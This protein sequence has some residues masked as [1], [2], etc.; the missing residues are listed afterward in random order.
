MSDTFLFMIFYPFLKVFQIR[1]NDLK[2]K[3]TSGR[4]QQPNTPLDVLQQVWFEEHC[5]VLSGQTIFSPIT[6]IAISLS[7]FISTDP[8]PRRWCLVTLILIGRV[9][10][11]NWCLPFAQ[12]H[13][14]CTKSQV[15][16]SPQQCTSSVQQTAWKT[17]NY[18]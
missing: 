6:S 17:F 2:E 9:L 8:P 7:T 10:V 15:Q 14:W 13:V 18:F 1:Y 16:P 5:D 3:N 11:N 12:L 4:G